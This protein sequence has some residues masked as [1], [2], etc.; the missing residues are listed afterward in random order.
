MLW[1]KAFHIVAVIT[2]FAAVFYLPRLFVYH[3]DAQA[4]GDARGCARFKVMERKL[5]FAIMTPS[6]VIAVA[7]GSVLWLGYGITGGWM[8]AKLLFVLILLLF[9][10]ACW[11][12][13]NDFKHDRNK[14]SRRALLIFNEIPVIPLL[15]GVILV[16]LKPF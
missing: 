12:L 9:H 15:G 3:H 14:L 7:L 4:E 2:W 11:K 5:F 16:V 10:G 6:A 1:I 13:L 8:H